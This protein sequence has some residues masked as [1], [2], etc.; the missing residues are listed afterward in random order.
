[1]KNLID[2]QVWRRLQSCPPALQA[3]NLARSSLPAP[4]AGAVV[5][6]ALGVRQES[7]SRLFSAKVGIRFKTIVQVLRIERTVDALLSC[8]HSVQD[9]AEIGGYRSTQAFTR[10]FKA[11]IGVTPSQFRV[12]ILQRECRETG[13]FL[14]VRLMPAQIQR[15]ILYHSRTRSALQF[16]QRH[17]E[18]EINLARIASHVGMSPSAFSR[19]FINTTG[20]SPASFVRTFRIGTA[21]ER[22]RGALDITS[23]A[24]SVG[25][26]SDGTCCRAFRRVTGE[27]LAQVLRG[28]V[29]AEQ[30]LHG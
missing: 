25:Y 9:L 16:V 7:L 5:A 26:A 24:E 18:G 12:G 30:S 20:V 15:S 22:I 19:Y 23:V 29:S 2:E 10:S 13:A 28:L 17:I 14:C 3:V 1:M 27:S 8:D 11:I 6:R 21:L 4:F